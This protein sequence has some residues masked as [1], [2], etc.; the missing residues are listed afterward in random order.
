MKLVTYEV[1][2]AMRIGAEVDGRIIHLNSFLA[3]DEKLPENMVSFL[4]LGEA[5][6]ESARKSIEN[7]QLK[8]DTSLGIPTGQANLQSPILNPS[9]IMMGGRNYLK[10]LDELRKEGASRQEKIVVKNGFGVW[11]IGLGPRRF[12]PTAQLEN[13]SRCFAK[14]IGSRIEYDSV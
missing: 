8:N 11:R 3:S 1:N 6:M 4:S 13:R 7:Y 9:K 5:G 12:R 14:R 10:H 2:G